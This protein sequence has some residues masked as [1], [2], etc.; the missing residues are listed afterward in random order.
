MVYT[1]KVYLTGGI[2]REI[3]ASHWGV[4]Q[5]GDLLFYAEKKDAN[6]YHAC[7]AG[8]WLEVICLFVSANKMMKRRI[9]KEIKELGG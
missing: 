3:N 4:T 9:R 1:W 6:P 7:A 2:V 5:N 8:Q